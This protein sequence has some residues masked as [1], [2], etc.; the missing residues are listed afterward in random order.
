[1]SDRVQV[2]VTDGQVWATAVVGADPAEVFDFLRRPVN[3][4]IVSGDRSVQGAMRGPEALAAGDRFGMSM[5]IGLPY[6][7]TSKV[8]EFEQDRL[9]AWC[10]FFGHRW[11]WELE[12]VG[13]GQTK[14]RETFDLTTA[15]IPAA[16]RLLGLPRAH[17][18]NVAKSVGNVAKHFS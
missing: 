14:V 10:H 13:P 3:H 11:R 12:P 4:S 7:V 8:V 9:I 1:M 17:S 2:Q 6:R 5:R 16:L 18:G 15:R